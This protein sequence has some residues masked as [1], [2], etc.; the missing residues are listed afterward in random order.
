MDKRLLKPA[1]GDAVDATA[2]VQQFFI[3]IRGNC[4]NQ[5]TTREPMDLNESQASL[6]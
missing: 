1:A 6:D 3:V 5:G 2:T 4:T